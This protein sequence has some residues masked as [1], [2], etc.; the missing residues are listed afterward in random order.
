MIEFL[1]I[2]VI[3]ALLVVAQSITDFKNK[4]EEDEYY[5]VDSKI[6]KKIPLKQR[7]IEGLKEYHQHWK[8]MK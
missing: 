7:I 6:F 3:V 1:L 8:D 4:D 2:L 5:D